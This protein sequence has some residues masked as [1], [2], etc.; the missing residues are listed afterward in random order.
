MLTT[1]LAKKRTAIQERWFSIITETYHA[2]SVAF[3]KDVKNQFANPVGSTI[4]KEVKVLFD[5][6]VDR[7]D[8]AA[9]AE[10]MAGINRIRAVQEFSASQAVAFIFFL[11]TA[12]REECREELSN[13]KFVNEL[14]SLESA[15]D[16]MALIAFDTYMQCRERLN[17]IKYSDFKRRSAMFG[18][19][20]TRSDK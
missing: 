5:C 1:L 14:L 16:A 18:S 17:D 8:E 7:A 20:T 10:A 6:L 12:I 9:I 11:K 4:S 19:G 3:F 15:I 2:D 13:P